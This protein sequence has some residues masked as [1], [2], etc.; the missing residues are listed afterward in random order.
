MWANFGSTIDRKNLPSKTSSFRPIAEDDSW[1]AKNL[2]TETV[3]GR[4]QVHDPSK[5][6][7][8]GP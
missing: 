4:N 6:K 8:P 3:F 7:N 2:A 5:S 1:I